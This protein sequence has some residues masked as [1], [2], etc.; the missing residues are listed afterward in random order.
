MVSANESLLRQAF[1]PACRIIGHYDGD[2]EGPSL[3]DFVAA[4]KAEARL[5]RHE[6]LLVKTVGRCDR[7]RGGR[8]NHR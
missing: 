7:R 1:H 5:Q 6:A 8:Q 3:D 2:L 4:I